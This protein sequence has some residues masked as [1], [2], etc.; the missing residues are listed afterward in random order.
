MK[1]FI[2]NGV[3]LEGLS[4]QFN[5]SRVTFEANGVL[6]FNE[7]E[8]GR[9]LVL[10]VLSGGLYVSDVAASVISENNL[11]AI[12]GEA[13]K[14]KYGV[15]I[16]GD[17]VDM[18]EDE[19]NNYISRK[20]INIARMRR[21]LAEIS[22]AEPSIYQDF[23]RVSDFGKKLKG[24]LEY[25]NYLTI[26]P[27]YWGGWGEHFYVYSADVDDALSKITCQ[28]VSLLYLMNFSVKELEFGK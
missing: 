15:F 17:S 25:G 2:D 5:F 27:K 22:A 10:G 18:V 14:S 16:H 19:V 28:I 21:G 7:A 26:W 24:A 9:R 8:V 4:D 13:T 23:L 6:G 1:I 12:L 3:E 11:L 20:K